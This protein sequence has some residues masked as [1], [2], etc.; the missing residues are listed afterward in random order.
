MPGYAYT[1]PPPQWDTADHGYA[2]GARVRLYT[3]THRQTS[4]SPHIHLAVTI[5][6]ITICNYDA[7]LMVRRRPVAAANSG[8]NWLVVVASLT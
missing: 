6:T 3:H 1:V 5:A 4:A 7:L 8:C 2:S